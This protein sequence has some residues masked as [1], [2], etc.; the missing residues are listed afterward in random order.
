MSSST[1]LTILKENPYAGH[2][3][4]SALE[5]DLLWEYAKMAALVKQVREHEGGRSEG[6][7]RMRTAADAISCLPGI[8]LLEPDW[9]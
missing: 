1:P 6:S 5:A 7:Q 4:L 8:H 2:P 3:E 9:S